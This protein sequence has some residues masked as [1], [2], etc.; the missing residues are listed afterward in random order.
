VSASTSP[1]SAEIRDY[2]LRR[3]PDAARSRFEA[4]YFR[5]DALLDR[6]E[7]EEDALVSDYVLGRLEEGERRLFEE[8]LLGTPYYRERVETTSRLRLKVEAPGLFAR[9]A[10][11][12]AGDAGLFPGRSGT[13]VAFGLLALLLLASFLSALRLKN[14][15]SRA[16]LDL[17]ARLARTS[18]PAVQAGV[19]PLAQTVVLQPE[20][21]GG[22]SLVT[23]RRAPG[24]AVLLSFPRSLLGRG[25]APW[26][27]ALSNGSS[28]VW[29]SGPLP[30]RD[31]EEGDVSLRLPPGVPPAGSYAVLLRI[32]GSPDR[33]QTLLGVLEIADR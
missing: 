11:S 24:G 19:M 30:A 21:S 2:L 20:Q 18:D 32:P 14:D 13:A 6:I 9:R 12:H 15:L 8:A 27:V 29:E 26:S 5:D 4:A 23:L 33:A 17:S 7:A 31:P 10:A 1:G 16:R 25:P 22:P 28:L 3:M